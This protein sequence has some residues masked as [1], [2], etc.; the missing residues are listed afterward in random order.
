MRSRSKIGRVTIALMRRSY[1]RFEAARELS[2]WCLHTTVATIQGK[3]VTVSRKFETIPG[4]EG[5]P[6]R[7][8]RYWIARDQ[9]EKVESGA[10]KKGSKSKFHDPCCRC[11]IQITEQLAFEFYEPTCGNSKQPSPSGTS[12][13]V[14]P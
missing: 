11:P 9:H 14:K 3:G 8:C 5:S 6:T 1:N 13:E 2:D 4:F 10:N 7:C 12:S